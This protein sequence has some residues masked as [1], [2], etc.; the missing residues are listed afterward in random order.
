[1]VIF[2]YF[3]KIQKHMMPP[4]STYRA[5][6][7]CHTIS[8]TKISIANYIVWLE[9]LEVM[10]PYIHDAPRKRRIRGFKRCIKVMKNKGFSDEFIGVAMGPLFVE[11]TD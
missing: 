1:M 7:M 11:E 3:R 2:L 10:L 6:T 9:K 4:I 5:A 8:I